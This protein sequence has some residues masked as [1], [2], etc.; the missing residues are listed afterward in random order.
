MKKLI[1]SE[2]VCFVVII[3]LVYLIDI[4]LPLNLN[5][6]GIRPREIAGLT[7]IIFSPFLHGSLF[8]I[9]SNTLPLLILGLIVRAYGRAIFWEVS[10]IVVGIGGLFAWLFSSPGIV[11]GASG[12]IFG[13]WSFAIVYG[14][15]KRSVKSLLFSLFVLLFYG[16]MIFSFFSLYANISWSGHLGGVLAGVLCAITLSKMKAKIPSV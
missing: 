8:H 2:P 6:W 15:L 14:L 16:T 4:V 3:W 11:I 13:Y 7:G 10:L 5:L 12:V 9:A 1:G